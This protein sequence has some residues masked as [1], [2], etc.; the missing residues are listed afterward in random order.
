MGKMEEDKI[1]IQPFLHGLNVITLQSGR[2]F[3]DLREFLKRQSFFECGV[4]H[5]NPIR[6]SNCCS[7]KENDV[8]WMLSSNDPVST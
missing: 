7:L 6:A 4:L 1:P 2:A 5:T 8:I 3:G